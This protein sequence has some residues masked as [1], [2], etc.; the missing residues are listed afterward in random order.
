MPV[1]VVALR[2]SGIPPGFSRG[3][4]PLK[5]PIGAP[6]YPGVGVALSVTFLDEVELGPNEET[7]WEALV[8]DLPLYRT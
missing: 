2:I 6:G 5:A 8:L 1:G 4:I 3:F 7:A